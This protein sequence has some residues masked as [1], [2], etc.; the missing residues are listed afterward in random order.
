MLEKIRERGAEMGRRLSV[1]MTGGGNSAPRRTSIGTL[2]A[3]RDQAPCP[4]SFSP[5]ANRKR[6][7]LDCSPGDVSSHLYTAMVGA[8]L[9][10]PAQDVLKVPHFFHFVA[11]SCCC[12]RVCP[13]Q[14]RRGTPGSWCRQDAVARLFWGRE[15]GFAGVG[16]GGPLTLTGN[17]Y[18]SE[19]K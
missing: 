19:F 4:L 5:N 11:L 6:T 8:L 7:S 13:A 17:K 14:P 9:A 1:G 15:G 12:C 3:G 18:S 2:P 10:Q 16:V